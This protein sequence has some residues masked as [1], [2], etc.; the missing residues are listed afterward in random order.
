LI[1]CSIGKLAIV[2]QII[3]LA[4]LIAGTDIAWERV[5]V[6]LPAKIFRESVVLNGARSA[7]DTSIGDGVALSFI[8]GAPIRIS[9][10]FMGQF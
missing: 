4:R 7:A 2:E 1:L 6:R 8:S 5:A 3:D 9:F 10:N